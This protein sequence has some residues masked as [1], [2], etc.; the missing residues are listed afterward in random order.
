MNFNELLNRII[1]LLSPHP[2]PPNLQIYIAFSLQTCDTFVCIIYP[3]GW[4]FS[5]QRQSILCTYLWESAQHCLVV[6]SSSWR[7]IF[8][9]AVLKN[10]FCGHAMAPLNW[11]LFQINDFVRIRHYCVAGELEP[12]ACKWVCVCQSV[13][14][15]G[16]RDEK[17]EHR[18][19]TLPACE[20]QT[21]CRWAKAT[22]IHT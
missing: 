10:S 6:H 22:S 15:V 8:E 5:L 4:I 7:R 19:G 9:T 1:Y 2:K 14:T 13:L 20:T 21:H 16:E 12:N 18:A 3:H 11:I 17:N